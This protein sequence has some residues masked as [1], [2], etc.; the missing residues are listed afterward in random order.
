MRVPIAWLILAALVAGAGGWLAAR[1]ERAHGLPVAAAAP[2]EKAPAPASVAALG[3]IEPR[4]GVI[5]VAGPPR[6]T[7]VIGELRVEEGD[8]VQRGQVLAVLAGIGVQRA[9]VARLSAELENARR[10]L[11]RKQG[12]FRRGATS[13][14]DLETAR[15][16]HD[17]ARAN[18]DRAQAELRLSEVVAP[19]DGQ[20]LE[21]HA[22]EGER[23]GAEGVAELGE[24]GAMYAVA[25][26]YETDIGRVRVGQKAVARSPALAGP[27]SGE[28]ER[29]GLKIGK[30][31]VL[32]TDPVADADARVVEV[33]IRLSDPAAAA[34]FTN[35][36]V[37]V[38]IGEK[39]GAE[40]RGEP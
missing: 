8:T 39:A 31:D 34:R 30:K 19:I 14:A 28:V 11:E 37:E 6:P 1:A 32:S 21:I 10:E 7:V 29:I 25:E 12:L 35:L 36:R 27:L 40:P 9:E 2:A 38:L 33:E 20:V 18:L 5:R 15:L 13:D 4:H 17:V 24:T 3:R 23:V 16:H 26:V 22:R